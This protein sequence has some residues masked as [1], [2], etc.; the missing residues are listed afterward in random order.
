MSEFYGQFAEGP[1]NQG[2]TVETSGACSYY[3]CANAPTPAGISAGTLTL[4]GGSFGTGVSL[5]PEAGNPG[6]Y[7]Y[8]TAGASF[9]EGQVLT[10]SSTGGI[11]P[12]F[13]FGPLM[14]SAPYVA[15]LTS[16][17][18]T[19]G[20]YTITTSADLAVA[21]TGGVAPAQ[22]IVEGTGTDAGA[23]SYFL[24]QWDATLGSGTVPAQVL[25]Q[26]AGQ[27]GFLV[28]GQLTTTN[29][30]DD[31]YAISLAALQY[32]GGTADYH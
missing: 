15:T 21:W 10:V 25:T 23:N 5:P 19:G 7:T 20:V 13:A 30:Q 28:Y 22:M 14:V 11:V 9:S 6:Q 12:A 18:A 27:T 29:L 4:Y 2:C 32:N 16:P 24:C 26:L 1:S 3:A 31:G 8:S 17:A